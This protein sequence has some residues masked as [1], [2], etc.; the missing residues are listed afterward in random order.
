[1][2]RKLLRQG[3][4]LPS[5]AVVGHKQPTREALL[6][7]AAAVGERRHRGLIEEV[8]DVTEQRTMQGCAFIDR[9]AQN[10]AAFEP[11]AVACR[12][13]VGLVLRTS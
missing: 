11:A 1:M 13:H 4:F 9:L 8:V 10:A 2:A 6:D 5:I 7:G 3:Q 12:L